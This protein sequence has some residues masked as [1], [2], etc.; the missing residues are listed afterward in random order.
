MTY[1]TLK[2]GAAAAALLALF[3]A[4]PAMAELPEPVRAMIDAAIATG[5][6][7]KVATVLEL[8]KTTNPDDTAEIDAISAEFNAEQQQLAAVEAA[9]KEAEIR[10]AG[11][12]DNWSGE[13]QIGAFRSTGNSSNTGITAGLEL[14][15]RGIDWRHKLTGLADFQRTNGV[16]TRE[17]FLVAYEPNYQL[18]GRIYVYGLGQYERDRFQGFSSRILASGGV[19]YRAIDT[20]STQLSVKAGPAYRKTSFIGGGSTSNIAGLAALD[21]DWQVAERVK[22][23]QDAS[24]LIQSGNSTYISTTGLE[25]GLGGNLSARIA[26]AVE[27]DTNP[28]AGAV[29]TD[30][31]TRFTLI[32]GF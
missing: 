4:A 30:T 8:A 15:R 6:A 28:P 22:L 1:L 13:G 5:D 9:A 26:Y 17:Q 14:T 10:S 32:Y 16:T 21:F 3:S 27:H 7:D 20:D 19:G 23:T 12:F 18:N 31:L 25:A 24:A 2:N 29:K 11:L